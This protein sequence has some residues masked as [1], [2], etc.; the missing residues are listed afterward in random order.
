MACTLA[1]LTKMHAYSTEDLMNPNSPI[2]SADTSNPFALLRRDS[3]AW[4]LQVW[5]S[6]GLALSL[7][8]I[9]LAWLPG[10]DLD[11]AFMVMG[12]VFCLSAAFA[13][14]KYVRDK[15]AARQADTPMWGLVVWGGFGLAMALTGW[16]LGP[17]AHGHTA[18]L[19]G[20]S[21]GQLAVPDLQR[22]HPG[23]AAARCPRG[24]SAAGPAGGPRPVHG[25]RRR[26]TTRQTRSPRMNTRSIKISAVLGAL[27][28][29]LGLQ[30]AVP[31]AA[32]AQ[33]TEASALSLLPVAVSVAAPVALLGAGVVLSVVA[34][35]T[36]ARG[37]VRV[38]ERASDGARMSLNFAGQTSAMVGSAVLVTAI[39]SGYILSAA[40][41]AIAFVPNAIG[42]ALLH[43]EQITR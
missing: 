6:F 2:P 5:V 22:L 29:G 1:P 32:H 20:L 10:D 39:G 40:G 35:E 28:L 13:L 11:R 12:Y 16:G 14:A 38:L 24:R 18:G 37:T 25:N 36:S 34:V 21:A 4:R 15:E 42:A 31:P 41:Q 17:V 23:Q 8:A 30:L 7:C 19:E 3:S 43:N 9:G 27:L 26:V 33:S